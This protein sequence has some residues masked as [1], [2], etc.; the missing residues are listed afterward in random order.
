MKRN[1]ILATLAVLAIALGIFATSAF[2]IWQTKSIKRDGA[3]HAISGTYYDT[4]EEVDFYQ[5]SGPCSNGRVAVF[6]VGSNALVWQDPTAVA[7][8]P[9]L[10]VQIYIKTTGTLPDYPNGTYIA[11]VAGPADGQTIN[12]G[13]DGVQH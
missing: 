8:C 4:P 1:A 11:L 6:Q 13:V 7:M 2:G 10:T 9:Y 3:W 12:V 5:A